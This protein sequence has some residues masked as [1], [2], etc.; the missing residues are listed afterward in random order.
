MVAQETK[1]GMTTI[2]EIFAVAETPAVR[3]VLSEIFSDLHPHFGE[4][5]T[6]L[7]RLFTPETASEFLDRITDFES[8]I[9]VDD[10]YEQTLQ[11]FQGQI[12]KSEQVRAEIMEK[13]YEELRPIETSYRQVWLFFENSVVEDGKQRKPVELFIYSADP[14]K[15]KNRES[16]TIEAIDRFVESRNDN[17]NFR[18]D[19]CNLVIPGPIPMDVREKLEEIA[20]K[21]GMLLI[22]DLADEKTY[23][24][25]VNHFRPDGR[26]EF[27]KRIDNKAASDVVLVGFL[28]LREPHWFERQ[29][30]DSDGIYAPAS[31]A[32]AG[33]VARTDRARNSM[34]QG[35]IGMKFGR[36]KGVEKARIECLISQMQLLS[37][38]MQVIPIMRDSDNHL[39]FYGCRTLADDKYGVYKFFTAYRVLSYIERMLRFR[40]LEVAGQV[41][42][43]EFMNQEIEEP[44]E[45]MLNEQVDKG[46]I[47]EYRLYVDK[48]YNKRMQGVCDIF[49]EVM[50]TGPAETFRVKIDVPEFKPLALEPAKGESRD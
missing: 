21:R 18:D 17:P 29:I 43:R 38:E 5:K 45:R 16:A 10:S 25:V 49:L 36:I 41:L 8:I 11:K 13:L 30:E 42:T 20:Y 12:D 32:F 48:D 26:Y 35:P 39:C 50:P 31:V 47:L 34:V 33:A 22:T 37:Q 1:T 44:I 28:K 14:S 27:L 4:T 46:A 23:R 7:M 6:D 40:L 2:D 3:R 9:S 19:I 24:Q 15:M